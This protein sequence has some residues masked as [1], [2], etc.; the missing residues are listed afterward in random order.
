[1]VKCK[2]TFGRTTSAI[3]MIVSSLEIGESNRL[4]NT[5]LTTFD[6]N[7]WY[8]QLYDCDS[9]TGLDNSGAT[10]FEPDIEVE[11]GIFNTSNSRL[12]E[13][14]RNNFPSQILAQWEMLRLS[15]F[16]EENIMNYL[17]EK[18]SNKIPEIN[19]NLDAWKKYITMG[20]EFLFACHGN[21]KH[22]ITR[23]IRERLIYMDTLLGYTVSTNDYITIRANKLGEVYLDIQVFQPMYFSVKFRN[24]ENGTGIITKRIGR[25]E[26]VRFSY[27][28]PVATDQEILV[29]GGRFIKDL[30]DLTN[31]NQTNL[32]LGNGTRL[33][34]VK[35]NDS[36]MLII[37]SI[38][39]CTML[40]E[41]DLR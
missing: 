4:K 18:I 3:L 41:V 20:T 2:D 31:M 38:S 19:Y 33:T 24:E 13:K 37:A 7:V 35:F 11:V 25:G 30:G 26:T 8:M 32:L 34:R 9:S 39:N 5:M 6:G 22:Q 14:L 21:R 40:Q 28:L 23:W 17:N 15:Y 27:N 16:T 36:P 10:K 29:Y 12:W 1:M